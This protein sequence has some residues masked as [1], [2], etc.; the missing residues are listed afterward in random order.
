MSGDYIPAKNAKQQF[1]RDKEEQIAK[2]TAEV[3]RLKELVNEDLAKER[4]VLRDALDFVVRATK[5][6]E[7]HW[8]MTKL[9]AA[10]QN[11]MQRVRAPEKTVE[12]KIAD[13]DDLPF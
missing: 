4:D 2:L 11:S 3:E 5:Y 7:P 6:D 9:D 12:S 8:D 13:D 10:I 1:E